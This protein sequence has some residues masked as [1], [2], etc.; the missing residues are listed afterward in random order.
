MEKE[1][2]NAICKASGIPEHEIKSTKRMS[3]VANARGVYYALCRQFNIPPCRA[4][5]LVNRTHG[6]LISTAKT[7]QQY[8]DTGDVR[9]C[10]LQEKAL[11][12]INGIS[13]KG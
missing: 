12:L 1:I 11:N 13:E 5:R 10:S 7:Y 4:A 2:L 6:A 9:A 8:I 3:D